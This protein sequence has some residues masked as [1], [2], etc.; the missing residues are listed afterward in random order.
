MTAMELLEKQENW[1]QGSFGMTK[2]N[3]KVKADDPQA[4]RWCI[5]MEF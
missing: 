3:R 4:C 1:C 5:Y 2:D